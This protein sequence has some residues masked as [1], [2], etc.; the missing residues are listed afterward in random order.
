M[1][2]CQGSLFLVFAVC[3][4]MRAFASQCSPALGCCGPRPD[5]RKSLVLTALKCV[6]PRVHMRKKL[7]AIFM[8]V[9]VP[10]ACWGKK[11]S[12]AITP[13]SMSPNLLFSLLSSLSTH[14]QAHLQKGLL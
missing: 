9:T 13:S 14:N 6:Q 10:V 3:A 5:E 4:G 2:A 8:Q 11:R 1:K 12:I 7:G